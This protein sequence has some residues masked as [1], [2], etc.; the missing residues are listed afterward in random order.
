MF[1]ISQVKFHIQNHG[2]VTCF[3]FGHKLKMRLWLSGRVLL[4]VTPD[5]VFSHLSSLF[6]INISSLTGFF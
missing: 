1:V 2:V 5:G 6:Y 4:Y 3:R